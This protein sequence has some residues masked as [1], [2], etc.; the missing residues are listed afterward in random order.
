MTR[1]GII[2]SNLETLTYRTISP[3]SVDYYLMQVPRRRSK[4]DSTDVYLLDLGMTIYQ[5]NGTGSNKNERF[6][7]SEF[8]ISL[9]DAAHQFYYVPG[10]A[11]RVGLHV[12]KLYM[13][14][15]RQSRVSSCHPNK[16]AIPIQFHL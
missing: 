10:I 8:L 16:Q 6:K 14:M 11:Y 7:V 9:C 1:D 5:W 15:Q 2:H 4:L 3:S 12:Y 13:N